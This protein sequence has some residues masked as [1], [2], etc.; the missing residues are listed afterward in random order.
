MREIGA[1]DDLRS[2][3]PRAYHRPRDAKQYGET[4]SFGVY[5]SKKEE[6]VIIEVMDY[7]AGTLELDKKDLRSLLRKLRR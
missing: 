3:G 1:G 6:A 5:A 7:H 2:S 4:A